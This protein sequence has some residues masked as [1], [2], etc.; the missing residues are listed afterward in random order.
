[1]TRATPTAS[2]RGSLLAALVVVGLVILVSSCNAVLAALHSEPVTPQ[3]S[4]SS[5]P[6]SMQA[7]SILA[8][9]YALKSILSFPSA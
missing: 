4:S 3:G 1:V 2:T 5:A 7:D 9:A 6:P 8:A